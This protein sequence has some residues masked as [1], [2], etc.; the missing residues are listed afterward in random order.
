[1]VEEGKDSRRCFS[2]IRDIDPFQAQFQ[3]TFHIFRNCIRNSK[4]KYYPLFRSTPHILCELVLLLLPPYRRQGNF[5]EPSCWCL[6]R[7]LLAF[8]YE[9]STNSIHNLIC[10]FRD[11][12]YIR[13]TSHTLIFQLISRI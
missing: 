12:F 13:N 11:S 7:T 4:R 1:M 9:C 10:I 8:Q 3:S 6:S 5:L 2:C